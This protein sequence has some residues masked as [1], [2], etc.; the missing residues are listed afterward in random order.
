MI[1]EKCAHFLFHGLASIFPLNYL[2]ELLQQ[3]D[4]PHIMIHAA[5]FQYNKE[6]KIK[7]FGRHNPLPNN[8]GFSQPSGRSLLKTLWEKEKMLVA[9]FFSFF[10][11]IKEKLQ[12]LSPIKIVICTISMLSFW[13]RLMFVTWQTDKPVVPHILSTLQQIKKFKML[14]QDVKILLKWWFLSLISKKTLREKGKMLVTSIFS[15]SYSVFQS[16]LSFGR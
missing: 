15:F 13:Q 12:N 4:A 1:G 14:I 5:T 10:Y 11:S 3:T 2:Q 6:L 9:S 7:K 8:P 16:L